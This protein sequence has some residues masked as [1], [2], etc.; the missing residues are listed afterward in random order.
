VTIPE[1]RPATVSDST[2]AVFP[3]AAASPGAKPQAATAGGNDTPGTGGGVSG[4]GPG[5][6]GGPATAS[7]AGGSGPGPGGSAGGDRAAAPSSRSALGNP[8][9][10]FDKGK[11]APAPSLATLGTKSDP[12]KPLVSPLVLLPL[13]MIALLGGFAVAEL[14]RRLVTADS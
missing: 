2:P 5:A 8:W 14:R 6:T 13:G 9:Q 12:L 10:A 11:L 7:N 1:S 4:R 3:T